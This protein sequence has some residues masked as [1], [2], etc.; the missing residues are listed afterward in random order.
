MSSKLEQTFNS[1]IEHIGGKGA[2]MYLEDDNVIRIVPKDALALLDDTHRTP[3]TKISEL[4]NITAT[5]KAPMIDAIF[6]L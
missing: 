5:N 2:R 3:I 4:E 6:A 1:L